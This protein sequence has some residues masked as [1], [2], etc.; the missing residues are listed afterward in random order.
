[1]KAQDFIDKIQ[2]EL[3]LKGGFSFNREYGFHPP[4]EGYIV[5]GLGIE[6]IFDSIEALS[7]GKE[8]ILTLLEKYGDK[9]ETTYLGGWVNSGDGKIHIEASEVFFTPA[10]AIVVGGERNQRAFYDLRE[11]KD[12]LIRKGKS[13]LEV[14]PDNKLK[15]K[16]WIP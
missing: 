11:G 3:Y 8:E 7:K 1:M 4:K 5:G 12:I 6:L 15:K 2:N 10:L 14:Q 9:D 13:N 16:K